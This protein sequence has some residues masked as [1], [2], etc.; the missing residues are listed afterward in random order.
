MLPTDNMQSSKTKKVAVIAV[1]GVG[2]QQP[3]DTAHRIGDL[4]QDLNLGQG[5]HDL[6]PIAAEQ[7]PVYYPFHEEMV[8]IDVRRR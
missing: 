7:L 5:P 4:L 2:D 6:P 1:H 3:S 8:H